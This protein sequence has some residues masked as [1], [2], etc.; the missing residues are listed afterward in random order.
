MY[1]GIVACFFHGYHFSRSPHIWNGVGGHYSEEQFWQPSTSLWTKMIQKF[2]MNVIITWRNASVRHVNIKAGGRLLSGVCFRKYYQ[3]FH[4]LCLNCLSGGAL[5][6]W[7]RWVATAFA[8]TGGYGFLGGLSAA[9]R[10]RIRAH[11]LR[12]ECVMSILEVVSS[13]RRH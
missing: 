1:F 2:G 5:A 10:R 11:A 8:L 6:N 12:L 13:R 3:W 4:T 7:I 9:P